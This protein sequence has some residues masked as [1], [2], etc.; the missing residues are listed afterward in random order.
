[1]ESVRVGGL[2]VV[3]MDCCAVEL[4]QWQLVVA[5]LDSWSG[6]MTSKLE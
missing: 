4:D 1:M 3:L 5:E 2:F 6:E